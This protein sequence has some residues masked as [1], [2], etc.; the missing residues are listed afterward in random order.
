MNPE[1]E[2]ASFR[3]TLFKKEVLLVFTSGFCVMLTIFTMLNLL[4]LYVVE[5]GGT[6]L[7]AG[8]QNSVFS[9]A[10]VAFRFFLGPLADTKGRKV[11]LVAGSFVFATAPIAIWFA[12]NHI[13]QI[14]A[15]IYHAIGLA[16]FLS[17]ASSLLAD[18]TP[19]EHRGKIFGLYRALLSFSLM[20][21]PGIGIALINTRGYSSL[22]VFTSIV[23][24]VSLVAVM[25]LPK[26]DMGS[27]ARL[28]LM[29]VLS[30]MIQLLRNPSLVL[31]YLGIVVVAAPYA[32]L[33][34]YLTM[35]TL[36]TGLID[37]P[38]IYFTVFAGAGMIATVF[39]GALA[40]RIGREKIIWP[41]IIL[42]GL[43]ICGLSMLDRF[44]ESAFYLSAL[45]S[46]IG[47]TV[48]LSTLV[49]WIIDHADEKTR[50]TALVLQ[51]NSIDIAMS[52]GP[53]LIGIGSM[54][55]ELSAMFLFLG[56]FTALSSVFLFSRSIRK[57]G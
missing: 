36:R 17:S 6:E 4:P 38:G 31:G 7:Q 13:F 11:L 18:H 41:S 48:A 14:I 47:Y 5:T 51:E 55:F 1:I 24:F 56:I 37:N 10:A 53:F 25:L 22:F 2:P 44:G 19:Y 16:T 29:K 30:A 52:I 42:L 26:E 46:G 20:I 34:A 40:D 57:A 12:P 50:A 45:L 8:I 39:S 3:S 54:K 27:S 35:F 21:G 43:G 23:A 15:R 32:S 49:I 9:I 33:L 28:E